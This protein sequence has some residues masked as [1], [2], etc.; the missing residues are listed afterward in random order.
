MDLYQV[1][2]VSR[3]AS[4]DEIGRAYRRL[5][6]RYHPGVNPGDRVAAERFRQLEVA[7]GVLGDRERRHEYDRGG[8]VPAAVVAVQATVSFEGFDFASPAE[9]PG[10]ATFSELFAGVFQDAARRATAPDRGVEGE[11]PLRLR[12]EDAIRGGEVSPL[13]IRHEG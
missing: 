1:L 10:A 3:A 5:A 8:A 11:T 6:R 9:G 7:Y 12:F 13:C 4:G 2:G